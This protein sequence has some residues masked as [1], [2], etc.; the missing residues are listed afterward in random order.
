MPRYKV[1]RFES[2][3]QGEFESEIKCQTEVL[4]LNLGFLPE[5]LRNVALHGDYASGN[6]ILYD[7]TTEPAIPL[8][9]LSKQPGVRETETSEEFDSDN[10]RPRSVEPQSEHASAGS[11]EMSVTCDC[12]K[13]FLLDSVTKNEKS[14]SSCGSSVIVTCRSCGNWTC[15]GCVVNSLVPPNH[16]RFLG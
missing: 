14:C 6:Y 7:P 10:K 11:V 8:L 13:A 1:Y 15:L 5:D 12:G 9:L 16:R 2:I 3:F 4:Q